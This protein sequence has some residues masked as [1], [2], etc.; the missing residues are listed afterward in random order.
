V[1][2]GQGPQ[3]EQRRCADG[4]AFRIATTDERDGVD[5]EDNAAVRAL[6]S[7]VVIRTSVQHIAVG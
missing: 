2:V 7:P 5:S 6:V 3:K 1:I 4:H